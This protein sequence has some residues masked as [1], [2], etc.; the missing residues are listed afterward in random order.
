MLTLAIDSATEACSAALFEDGH[1]LQGTCE[2][3]GRGHVERL[4]P[5]IAALP[6]KG[7]A[8]RLVVSLGPGSFTGVRIGL[9]TARA[10]GLAWNAEVL[11]YPTLALIAAMA[12]RQKDG[13]VTVC[14]TG[15]HGEWFVQNF[16]GSGLPEEA[17]VSLPPDNAASFA[18][19]Q[20]VAGNQSER[21][22]ELR[23][24]GDA[25]PIL[26]DARSLMLLPTSLFTSTL[27]PLY[28]RPPDARLPS[29]TA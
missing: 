8:D 6:G 19:H 29:R 28:G 12:Q 25:L 9:A 10:L 5:M 16:D 27:A 26:P 3:I 7:R 15:G 18:R 17:L 24:D 21:L 23:G 4:V 20:S 2:T 1:L 22:V 14:T 11:G 13:P